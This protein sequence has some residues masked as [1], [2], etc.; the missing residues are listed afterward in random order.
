MGSA[1]LIKGRVT[2]PGTFEAEG[3]VIL[4]TAPGNPG[5]SGNQVAVRTAYI[6]LV[7]QP[8]DNQLPGTSDSDPARSR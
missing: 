1:N 7:P 4:K 2:G 6:D 8:G 5:N 3:G